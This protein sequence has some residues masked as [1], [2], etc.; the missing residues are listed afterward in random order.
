L[1]NGVV[2]IYCKKYLEPKS[3]LGPKIFAL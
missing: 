3:D 2:I 1:R